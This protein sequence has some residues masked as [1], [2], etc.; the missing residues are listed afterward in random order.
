MTMGILVVLGIVLSQVFYFSTEAPQK[1][2]ATTEQHQ[3]ENSG[4]QVYFSVPSSSLPSSTH[5]ELNPNV[6]L[7]FEILFE[8]EIFEIPE[9]NFLSLSSQFFR[10]I[11]GVTIS[12]N[13]P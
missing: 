3:T 11:F 2:Q 8:E 4:E 1:K 9:L 7:L 5:L 6:F 13:A 12:P 10:T